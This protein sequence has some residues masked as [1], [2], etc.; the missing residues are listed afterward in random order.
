MK[1]TISESA[2][3]TFIQTVKLDHIV[4][5][6]E[7]YSVIHG[8]TNKSPSDFANHKNC[9]LGQWYETKGLQ[10]YAN[11]TAFR[12]IDQPHAE[13]HNE[14]AKALEA[15]AK[16]NKEQTIIALQKMEDA[17]KR[18]MAYLDDLGNLS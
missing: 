16:Q 2:H 13:V 11:N 18:V 7:V 12:S 8:L 4:W 1:S 3:R 5:K 6:S 9:R 10:K 15:F 17:S 14:G